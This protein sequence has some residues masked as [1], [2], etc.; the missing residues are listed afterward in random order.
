LYGAGDRPRSVA[1]G[2]LDGDGDADLAVANFS[3]NVSVLLGGCI[4]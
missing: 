1:I 3:D 4:P 2:D